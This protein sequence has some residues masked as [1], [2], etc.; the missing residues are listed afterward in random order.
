MEHLDLREQVRILDLVRRLRDQGTAI[1]MSLHDPNFALRACDHLILLDEH[2]GTCGPTL[3][4]G[5]TDALSR[6]YGISLGMLSGP[7]GPILVP[8]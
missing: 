4:V 2:R 8:G 3:K 5:T 7:H 1:L 6:L